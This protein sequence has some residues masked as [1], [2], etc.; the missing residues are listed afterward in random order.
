MTLMMIKPT[1][2]KIRDISHLIDVPRCAHEE[3]PKRR[4]SDA[5]SAERKAAS[6]GRQLLVNLGQPR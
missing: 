5:V 1:K 3:R 2:P 4:L 6:L